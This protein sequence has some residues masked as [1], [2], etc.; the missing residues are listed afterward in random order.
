MQ[1]VLAN[2]HGATHGFQVLGDGLQNGRFAGAVRADE[3]EHFA[4]MQLDF[5]VTDQGHAFVTNR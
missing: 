5:N 3:R 2:E 4:L 1:V